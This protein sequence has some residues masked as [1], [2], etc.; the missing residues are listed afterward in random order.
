M[1]AEYLGACLGH[2]G[3]LILDKIRPNLKVSALE[4]FRSQFPTEYLEYCTPYRPCD[5]VVETLIRAIA[6]T[7]NV[8]PRLSPDCRS[9]LENESSQS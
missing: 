4:S 8:F 7:F 5:A 6:V 9:R 2:A 1:L 3:E